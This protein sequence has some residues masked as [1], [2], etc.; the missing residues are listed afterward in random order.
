MLLS[1]LTLPN[2]FIVST[3]HINTEKLNNRMLIFFCLAKLSILFRSY[4]NFNWKSLKTISLL[5]LHVI[6]RL[7]SKIHI[8]RNKER[9][10]LFHFITRLM[11]HH[12]LE[13]RHTNYMETS[14]NVYTTDSQN[15][16]MLWHYKNSAIV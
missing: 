15:S 5:V 16:D 8:V 3:L 4:L 11:S 13:L 14:V 6:S 7:N 9:N 1:L 10:E 12:F 2:D